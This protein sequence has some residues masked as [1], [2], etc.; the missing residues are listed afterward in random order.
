MERKRKITK[1]KGVEEC[2]DLMVSGNATKEIVRILGEKYGISKSAIEKWIAVAR[3][4]AETRQ[5]EAE[6]LRLRLTEEVVVDALKSGLKSDLELEVFLC[7]LALGNF[8]TEEIVEGELI[9]RDVN[10]TERIRAIDLVFKKRG[11]YITKVA[12]TDSEGNDI[13]RMMD[14][15]TPEE[16][17]FLSNIQDKVG[18]RSN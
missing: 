3:P 16:M 4:L 5:K 12:Q 10:P 6:L 9:L 17:L 13:E 1:A 7:Q 15:L 11:A 8:Q 14:K 2:C 18:A